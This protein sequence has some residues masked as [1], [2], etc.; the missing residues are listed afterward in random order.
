MRALVKSERFSMQSTRFMRNSER[1]PFHLSIS[2]MDPFG[3]LT[4][5]DVSYIVL[6]YISEI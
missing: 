2:L 1:T 3:S 4:V 5:A 6:S